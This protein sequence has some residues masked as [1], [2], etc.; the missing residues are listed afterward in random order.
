SEQWYQS[1]VLISDR[2]SRAWAGDY[3]SMF[4]KTDGT[5]WAMGDNSLGQL[6]D[7]T[8]VARA[9][10]INVAYDVVS[11]SLGNNFSLFLKRDGTLWG[12]GSAGGGVLGIGNT[13]E[14]ELLPVLI[15]SD[16]A[17]MSGGDG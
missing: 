15:A 12:M 8:T 10:P 5:L 11:A 7:G 4:L 16:V 2:V 9:E 1:P 14:S 6:G 3:F 17:T 13:N